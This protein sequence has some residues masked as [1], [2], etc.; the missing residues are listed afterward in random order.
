MPSSFKTVVSDIVLYVWVMISARR[1]CVV[2]DRSFKWIQ[3]EPESYHIMGK[4]IEGL[5]RCYNLL[6]LY[7]EAKFLVF[8]K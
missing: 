8:W 3:Y 1:K 4:V 5:E 6:P 2:N 7:F